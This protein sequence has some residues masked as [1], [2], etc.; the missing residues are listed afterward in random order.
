MAARGFPA[1][2]ASLAPPPSATGISPEIISLRKKN[3]V[4][5]GTKWCWHV[6]AAVGFKGKR[7]K[8][9]HDMNPQIAAIIVS[10]WAKVKRGGVER[11]PDEISPFNDVSSKGYASLDSVS[12][13]KHFAPSIA[14]NVANWPLSSSSATS[15]TLVLLVLT[16]PS[17]PVHRHLKQQVKHLL[18]A[19]VPAYTSQTLSSPS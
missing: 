7:H 9:P 3:G 10:C 12:S 13:R 18:E 4:A 14:S 1:K 19:I 17:I 16:W 5:N 11:W 15:S 2:A 6:V 8:I